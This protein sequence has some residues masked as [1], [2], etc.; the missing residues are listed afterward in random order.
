LPLF[1]RARLEIF[2]PDLPK[3]VYRRLR[4]ALEQELT[5]TFGGCTVARS[6]RGSYLSEAGAVVR[7]PIVVVFSDAPFSLASQSE[8]LAEYADAL[9]LSAHEALDEEAIL[10]TVRSVHHSE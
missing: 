1:E 3:P 4:A 9:R 10:V 7:D 6:M 5:Y 2:L 8:R